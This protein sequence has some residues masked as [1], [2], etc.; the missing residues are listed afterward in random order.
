MTW[1]TV[2]KKPAQV[3]KKSVRDSKWVLTNSLWHSLIP[4]LK[5]R[6]KQRLSQ[7]HPGQVTIVTVNWNSSRYLEVLL[8]L[9]RARSSESTRILVVDNA[10]QDGTRTLLE[11]YPDV[12]VVWLPVNLGH[13]IAL[14]IGFLPSSTLSTLLL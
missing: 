3:L 5:Y 4:I 14:D 2:L 8:K 7:L 9:V 12:K 13:D 11:A 1:L 6:A 10:S